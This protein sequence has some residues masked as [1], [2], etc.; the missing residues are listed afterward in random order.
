MNDQPHS[1]K[2]EYD[3]RYGGEITR[4]YL[5]WKTKRLIRRLIRQHDEA[6]QPPNTVTKAGAIRWLVAEAQASLNEREW[7]A[8]P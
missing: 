7:G 8:K 2:I 5:N 4:W 1:H 3:A 6:S